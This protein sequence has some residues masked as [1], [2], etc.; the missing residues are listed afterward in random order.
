M[1]GVLRMAKPDVRYRHPTGKPDVAVDDDRAAM[2]PSVKPCELAELRRPELLHFAACRNQ[3]LEVFVG[4]LEAAEAVEEH[5]H[6]HTLALL[7]FERSKQLVAERP[8]RPDVHREI[9]GALRLIDAVEQGRHELVAI[10]KDLNRSSALDRR[11]HNRTERRG[12][13]GR[14]DA[15]RSAI[16]VDTRGLVAHGIEQGTHHGDEGHDSDHE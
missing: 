1:L 8:F 12:E 9:D 7:L 2:V 15:G 6:L 14:I 4:H 11:A 16:G 5:P 13:V 3:R 10:V